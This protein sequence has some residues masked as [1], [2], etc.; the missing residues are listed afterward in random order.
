MLFIDLDGV[1]ADF[2]AHH[3]AIFG[4]WPKRDSHAD[5]NWAAVAAIPHFYRDIPPTADQPVL[6]R[7]VARVRPT[8][9][10]GTPRSVPQA[11]DDK[12]AWVHQHL[13]EAV[14]VICCRA[15][16]KALHASPGDI[17]VDDWERYKPLWLAKGGRW[18]TH[19]GAA[20]TIAA[21][22]ELGF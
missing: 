3:F 7:Y 15:R 20:T 6:W 16:D 22:Q 12:R 2:E 13:G 17:L 11:A 21:L 1:L 19:R 5:V 14:P 18:V 4:T 8:V 9:L 10:T